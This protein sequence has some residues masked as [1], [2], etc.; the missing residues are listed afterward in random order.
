MQEKN[1]LAHLVSSRQ[2]LTRT[3]G[4]APMNQDRA[5]ARLLSGL[6]FG[7]D[8]PEMFKHLVFQLFWDLSQRHGLQ[9]P[10]NFPRHWLSTWATFIAVLRKSGGVATSPRYSWQPTPE[11]EAELDAEE[12]REQEIEAIFNFV[13]DPRLPTPLSGELGDRMNDLLNPV[14]PLRNLEVFR[15]AY[16]LALEVAAEEG[17]RDEG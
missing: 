7:K 4:V 17:A 15:V 3:F 9:L 13:N 12:K 2:A 5:L 10:K 16:P 14:H 1:T 6:Y 11:E 8:T